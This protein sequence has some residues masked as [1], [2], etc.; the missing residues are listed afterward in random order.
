MLLTD[1]MHAVHCNAVP[2]WSTSELFIRMPSTN[3]EF[4]TVYN[5]LAHNYALPQDVKSSEDS[6]VLLTA[7]LS[8]IIYMQ[9]CQP[10]VPLLSDRDGDQ[11][12]NPYAPLSSKSEF[13]RLGSDMTAALSRWE[14]HFQDKVGSNILALCYFTKLYLVCPALLELPSIA[15]YGEVSGF[16]QKQIKSKQIEIPDEAMDLAWLV[17]DQCDKSSKSIKQHLSI[18]LPNVLFMSA[19]VVWQRLRSQAATDLKFGTLKV[20]SM[21][22]NEIDRL[23]W[24]CCAE[25]TKTLDRLMQN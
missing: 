13:G 15:G 25:M 19:L 22:K 24:P 23:P 14:N 10:S 2:N 6:L 16:N 9:R 18:W 12:R 7:L 20:L 11:L 17:L 1:I 3:H 5:S 8:D 21:F 4:R